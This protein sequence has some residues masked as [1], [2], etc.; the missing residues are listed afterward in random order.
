MNSGFPTLKLKEYKDIYYN[1]GQNIHWKISQNYSAPH[2]EKWHAY[3]DEEFVRKKKGA[4][5][6]EDQEMF[7]AT[8]ICFYRRILRIPRTNDVTKENV[9][10]KMILNIRKRKL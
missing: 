9:T 8:M 2:A 4:Y 10:R 1:I 6:L 3:K 5:F 7:E